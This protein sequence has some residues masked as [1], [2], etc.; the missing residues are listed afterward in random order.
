MRN[1]AAIIMIAIALNSCGWIWGSS[2]TPT[3]GESICRL[4]PPVTFSKHDTE[5]TIEEILDY[6]IARDEVCGQVEE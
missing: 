3:I 5:Q 6:M 4:F 2:S 1:T